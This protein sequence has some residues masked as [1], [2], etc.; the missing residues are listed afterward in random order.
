MDEPVKKSPVPQSF[1]GGAPTQNQ[2]AVNAKLKEVELMSGRLQGADAWK[3]MRARH[4]LLQSEIDTANDRLRHFIDKKQHFGLNEAEL[5]TVELLY[6]L[7]Q[8]LEQE[9]REL[10]P[11]ALEQA[12]QSL[13]QPAHF[14]VQD[15]LLLLEEQKQ[16]KKGA[17]DS[18]DDG[19]DRALLEDP[20]APRNLLE[21]MLQLAGDGAKAHDE[22]TDVHVA[23][24]RALRETVMPT[25]EVVAKMLQR[26]KNLYRVVDRTF[27]RH[28]FQ[29]YPE[30]VAAQ[31]A[32]LQRLRG[33]R[34]DSGQT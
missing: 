22:L 18:K 33:R 27:E 29:A 13:Q 30:T 14:V 28:M 12:S 10:V 2:E 3:Y 31:L 4:S 11:H 9:Q 17:K 26:T 16:Q 8:R 20:L 24:E 6:E 15:P 25:P 1:P 5:R 34:Q 21:V 19:G 32:T 23:F 7:R